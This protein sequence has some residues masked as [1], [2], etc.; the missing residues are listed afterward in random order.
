MAIGERVLETLALA[1]EIAETAEAAQDS[2]R[3]D[4]AAE[5]E[6]M[7]REHP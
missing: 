7:A 6:R 2:N 4:V 1:I 5:A 3:V